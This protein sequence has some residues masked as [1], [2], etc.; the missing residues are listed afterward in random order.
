MTRTT[1]LF[2]LASTRLTNIDGEFFPLYGS[3]F[4]ITPTGFDLLLKELMP[5][6]VLF[7]QNGGGFVLNCT[8][9][10]G[11]VALCVVYSFTLFTSS[12][13]PPQVSPGLPE[14]PFI[15][16]QYFDCFEKCTI[17]RCHAQMKYAGGALSLN[18]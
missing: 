7:E 13:L 6:E 17:L 14:S 4:A 3:F 10:P 16:D 5:A 15:R 11:M 9:S 18:A 8:C 12:L 2:Y 1:L